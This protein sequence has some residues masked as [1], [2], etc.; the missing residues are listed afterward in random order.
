MKNWLQGF[1]GR[2][3]QAKGKLTKLKDK[4]IQLIEY[5]NKKDGVRANRL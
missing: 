1:K 2:F 3:K 4:T 5:E